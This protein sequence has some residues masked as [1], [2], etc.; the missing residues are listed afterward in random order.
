[1]IMALLSILIYLAFT[2]AAAVGLMDDWLIIRENSLELGQWLSQGL[3]AGLVLVA[4]VLL[5]VRFSAV[6][7]AALSQA[8]AAARETA[9]ARDVLQVRTGALDRYTHLLETTAEIVRQ[10]S[11][12]RHGEEMLQRAVDLLVERL[13]VERA[14]AYFAQQAGAE[15][16]G[17]G[18]ASFRLLPTSM[19]AVGRQPAAGLRAGE[20]PEAE[21]AAL[22]VEAPAVVVTAVTRADADRLAT[23]Q[24]VMVDGDGAS[25]EIVLLLRSG[26]ML[27]AVLHLAGGA[28]GEQAGADDLDALEVMGDQLAVALENARRFEQA[29]ARLRDLD[30]LQRRYSM[31]AWQRFVEERGRTA[32]HWLPL[33][34]Q[35]AGA[36]PAPRSQDGPAGRDAL[37]QEVWGSLF[38]RAKAEGRAVRVLDEDSGRHL[39]AMPV[40]LR[41]E[42]IGMLGFHRPRDAGAWQQEEIAA[43]EVVVGRMAFA[44]ENLRLLEDAQSRAARE[45]LIDQIAGQVQRSLDPDNILKTA[46]RELGRALEV[47]WAAIEVTGPEE[48][49]AG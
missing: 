17:P 4:L 45:R 20:A 22:P 1:M 9:E 8:R 35:A 33:G 44:A 11:M 48:V 13:D 7:V 3:S 42:V 28:L 24:A 6:Q 26:G 15:S 10:A 2:I 19:L 27:L 25:S 47:E 46:V 41:E 30:T 37:A 43:I 29:E 40:R 21:P 32:Y 18:E 16:G 23:S 14:A 39:L 12:L 38:E 34:P 49:R 31:D 36:P 5:L